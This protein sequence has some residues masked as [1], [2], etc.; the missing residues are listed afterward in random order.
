[1][2]FTMVLL[3]SL[4]ELQIMLEYTNPRYGE[5]E[6]LTLTASNLTS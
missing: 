3:A 5:E 1:M 2:G 4:E 6:I